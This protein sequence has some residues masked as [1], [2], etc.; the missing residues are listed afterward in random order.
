MNAGVAV[1]LG[2][3]TVTF[4]RRPSSCGRLHQFSQLTIP[5]H[6][7]GM[8]KTTMRGVRIVEHDD[9]K[10]CKTTLEFT[11]PLE[12]SVPEA[13]TEVYFLT[14]SIS[15]LTAELIAPSP[16]CAEKAFECSRCKC[17]FQTFPFKCVLACWISP[18]RFSR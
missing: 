11:T 10:G 13:E 5:H 8:Y 12:R 17:G 4:D 14:L 2:Y 15:D 6:L 9:S 16:D 3:V 1:E 7:P 18:Q